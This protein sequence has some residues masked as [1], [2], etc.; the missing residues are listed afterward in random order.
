MVAKNPARIAR[1]AAFL[2]LRTVLTLVVALYTSRVV[3][4]TLGVDNFGIFN[5]VAGFVTIFTFFN[6]SASAATARFLNFEMGSGTSSRL[7][8]TFSS[9]L[10]L[11]I[12]VAAVVVVLGETVGLWFVNNWLVIAP[13]RMFAANW[14]YQMAIIATVCNIVQ[15][16]FSAAVLAHERMDA[17]A[18][19][20]LINVVLKL[21]IA[22]VLV[23]FADADTLV[24][25]ATMFMGV[26]VLTMLMWAVFCWRKF[27]ETRTRPAWVKGISRDMLTFSGSD[28]YSS[29]C[30]AGRVQGFNVLLNWFGGAALN[31]AA[32]LVGSVISA[33]GQLSD[34]VIA[35]FRPQ[36]IQQYAAG[37]YAY[38]LRLLNN[39]ARFSFLLVTAFIVPVYFDVDYVLRLWL[40][41]YPAYTADFCRIS[42]LTGCFQCLL[43][44]LY[45]GVH[46]TGRIKRMSF[47]NGTA[48]LL[49]LPV[50]YFL[51]KYTAYAPV[52]YWVH[53]VFTIA[54]TLITSVILH[55]VFDRFSVWY[56]WRT[57]VLPSALFLALCM[58]AV[59]P[60]VFL[61]DN[62][63]RLCAMYGVSLLVC[64]ACAFFFIL[65]ASGRKALTA[66]LKGRL[67]RDS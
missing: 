46:A 11:H 4:D 39:S 18:Y 53:F 1:N 62:F 55:S 6:G 38:S 7:A 52:A 23:F 10:F 65:D 22:L 47:I 66:K 28:S 16:P 20:S 26:G 58:L 56:Y 9:A 24:I 37:D 67:R 33:L 54:I 5:L 64:G 63:G 61:P 25:Y 14:T 42:L 27:E 51:L 45:P 29:A 60:L 43:S 17:Y 34:T 35:A 19:L 13:E 49:E 41:E 15:L 48:Y 59:S 44:G 40:G 57:C 3:L 36:L 12:C 50:A 8:L 30:T 32:G 2:Y 21:V 31:A